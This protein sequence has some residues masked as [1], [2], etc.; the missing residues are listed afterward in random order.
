MVPHQV[1]Y[2]LPAEWET[3]QA[4]WL[5]W[6]HNLA[7]WP[8][9][10]EPIPQVW[11]ELARTIAEFEPVCVL[12]GG[13]EV[14]ASAQRLIGDLPG[15]T[16]YD[17][18]TND[19]WIRDHG[20]M[21]LAG[22]AGAAPALIDWKYNAWGGK[23]PPFDLDDAVPQRVAE[24][25]SHRR[26]EPG[27]VLEGGAIDGNGQ[28]CVLVS[29]RCL[30]NPTRNANLAREAAERLLLDYCGAT[31]VLWL[32][33]E[34]AGD[35]TD[36][37]VDQFARF[38]DAGTVAVSVERDPGDANYASLQEN[39]RRLKAATDQDGRPLRIVALP[40]PR[41]VYFQEHRLPASYANFYIANGVVVVP[42]FD[43]PADDEAV[44]TLAAL[45]PD[46]QIRGLRAVD[47]A[48]GLGAVHC[49]TQQQPRS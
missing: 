10:F 36:G 21:F 30:L 20:P 35:D 19:A 47:L 11:A 39:Q 25:L 22:P 34:L 16:L 29:E 12:A 40:T 38:V 32:D 49:V 24:T 1:G 46:R 15:V 8:G 9:A 2:R 44:A 5:S 13:A 18:P 3:H 37:H 26:F 41:P 14:F 45:F 17:I 33:A 42:Q 27:V 6:P 31:R 4:T 28:G 43:D 23:Y 7:T 48:W